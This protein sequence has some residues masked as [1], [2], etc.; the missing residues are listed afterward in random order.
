MVPLRRTCASRRVMACAS[1]MGRGI[2]CGVSR[3]A[4]PNIRP[5]SPAPPLSTPRAMSGDCAS[6]AVIT[7]Q[8]WLSKPN[9]A[10]S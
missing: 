1:M 2:N 6:M 4:K 5:W 7:A 9:S 3:Q 10:W 8:V